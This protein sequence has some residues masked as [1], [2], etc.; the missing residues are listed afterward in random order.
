MIYITL[1]KRILDKHRFYRIYG[2]GDLLVDLGGFLVSIFI[3][4]F[5]IV[6][7]VQE[8]MLI[9]SLLKKAYQAKKNDHVLDKKD[10]STNFLGNFLSNNDI[11]RL[12]SVYN[13]KNK[14]YQFD[15]NKPYDQLKRQ[16]QISKLR[17]K[18]QNDKQAEKFSSSQPTIDDHD[19]D[20]LL[21][22]MD[23][24][25]RFTYTLRDVWDYI[26]HCICCKSIKKIKLD[27]ELKKH[28]IYKRGSKK[29]LHELD[30]I[31]FLKSIRQ[32]KLITQIFLNQNQKLM[33]RFQKK[34]MIDTEESSTDSDNND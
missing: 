11:K 34:N 33:L 5:L 21:D 10:P 3:L 28:I 14:I 29:L 25:D 27:P 15:T 17:E 4:G 13:Q 19:K 7:F 23:R 30:C 12:D 9:G 18:E 24:R 22:E 8:R 1:G 2:V 26:G 16:Y 6:G 32:L 31:T 20:R